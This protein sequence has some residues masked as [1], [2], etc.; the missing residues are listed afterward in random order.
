MRRFCGRTRGAATAVLSSGDDWFRCLD[1]Q[2]DSWC[3][4][5]LLEPRCEHRHFT[6]GVTGFHSQGM[7]LLA[8]LAAVMVAVLVCKTT[9]THFD[10]LLAV[11]AMSSPICVNGQGWVVF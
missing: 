1:S 6:G 9:L 11:W 7:I 8:L 2:E 10:I 5:C 4:W 3:S